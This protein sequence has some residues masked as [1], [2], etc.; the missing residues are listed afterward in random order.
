M[1]ILVDLIQMIVHKCQLAMKLLQ[2]YVLMVL[3]LHQEII[4]KLFSIN[5][6]QKL[7]LDVKIKDVM[8]QEANVKHKKNVL[9]KLKDVL[10]DHVYQIS[11]VVH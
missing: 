1:I 3:V 4:V 6:I 5:V 10:M 11:K 8:L 7:Q 2:F 9:K